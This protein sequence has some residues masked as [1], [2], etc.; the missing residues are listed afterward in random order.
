LRYVE[1]LSD[2]RTMLADFFSILL[3]HH[4]HTRHCREA[5][6]GLWTERLP[7]RSALQVQS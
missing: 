7:R 3:G 2:A 6:D 5:Q 4:E 1:S